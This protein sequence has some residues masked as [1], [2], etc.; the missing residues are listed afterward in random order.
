MRDLP[1]RI[2]DHVI[3]Y[4]AVNV[5]A[6]WESDFSNHHPPA[7]APNALGVNCA[8]YLIAGSNVRFVEMNSQAERLDFSQ[9]SRFGC[10]CAS[11]W[12][13][14]IGYNLH[15]SGGQAATTLHRN[16]VLAGLNQTRNV[17]EDRSISA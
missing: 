14:V 17:H 15:T 13:V 3:K 10:Y 7:A 6:W 11:P 16:C 2:A 5:S 4:S 12:H 1:A 8:P 9:A